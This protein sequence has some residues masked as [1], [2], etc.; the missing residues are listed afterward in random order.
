M[1]MKKS[2]IVLAVSMTTGGAPLLILAMKRRMTTTTT[3]SRC[4]ASAA[5]E[6]DAGAGHRLPNQKTTM[7][8]R[9]CYDWYLSF[10]RALALALALARFFVC[11]LWMTARNYS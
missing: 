6:G 3:M 9:S 7:T 2:P 1:T 11:H 5:S 4:A 10:S 8:R